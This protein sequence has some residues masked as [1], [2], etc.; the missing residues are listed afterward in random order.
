M[1]KAAWRASL[2]AQRRVL[3]PGQRNE[4][5]RLLAEA[6]GVARFG[7]TVCAYVPL[8]TEPGDVGMLDA[9]RGGG[10]RVLLPVI[11]GDV[12]HW[13]PYEGT[14]RTGRFGIGEPD[15]EALGPEAL[16]EVSAMLVP[17]LAVDTHGVRLGKG[18]GYYDRSI[19]ALG[20]PLIAVVRDEEFLTELPAE[21]HDVRM[22][23]VLTP[24]GGLR[25]L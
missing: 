23:H 21:D 6:V 3:D 4:D 12:L 20:C 17:A 14:L 2:R 19:G 7:G 22:S 25:A 9:L 13:A 16:A 8:A 11:D 18:G 15:T 1:D 10:A 5:A 24:R